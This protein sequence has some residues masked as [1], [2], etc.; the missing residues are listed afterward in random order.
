MYFIYLINLRGRA[1]MIIVFFFPLLLSIWPC[2]TCI[3]ESLLN[4]FICKQSVK[5]II[6]TVMILFSLSP[7]SSNNKLGNDTAF[8]CL[9]IC[10]NLLLLKKNKALK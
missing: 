7:L 1:N 2:G 5:H 4:W 9:P 3:L 10:V 6:R 8:Y